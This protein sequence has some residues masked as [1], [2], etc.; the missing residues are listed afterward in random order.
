MTIVTQRVLFNDAGIEKD[1]TM[2][3]CNY[4]SSG[5][6]L[7]LV[8]ADDKIY[9]ASDLPFNHKWIEIATANDT[10]TVISIANWFGGSDGWK[11]CVDVIDT[12]D[13]FKQSG[14]LTWKTD[15]QKGWNIERDSDDVTGITN[16]AIYNMYWLR[17]TFSANLKVTTKVKSICSKFSDDTILTD[18]YPDLAN[19]DLM[20]AFEAGKTTWNDQHF[21]AAEIITRDLKKLNVIKSSAQL[22]NFELFAEAGV[23][24][25]AEL[26]YNGLGRPYLD[27]KKEARAAYD[28]AISIKHFDID[29]N[30]DGNLSPCEQQMTSGNLNR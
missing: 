6:T 4:R 11:S 21:I 8:A 25:V 19:T 16:P 10:A 15:Q 29:E 2:A 12:T 17:L 1:I 27:Q 7:P 18:Y 14:Y 26:V 13:G 9:I 3:V 20:T 22:L 5:Y 24:K 30:A 23:H 28:A